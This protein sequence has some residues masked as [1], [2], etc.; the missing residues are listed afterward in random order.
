M[1]NIA[2]LPGGFKPPHAGHYAVAKYLSQKSKA[3]V[4]VRVGSKERGSITQAMS[5]KIWDIYGI[6]AEPAASDSPIADVFKY[7][8]EKATEEDTIYVGTGE[9]DYPRFKVLTDPSFKPD[10]YKKYNPKDVKVIEIPIPPQAGGVSGTKM[11]E[12][13]MNDQKDLFQKYLPDHIDKDKIWNIVLD[14]IQEDLYNPN[15]HVLDYMKSSEFKAGYSKEDD[16]PPGY[17]YRRGGMYSGGGM[18]YGGM[19]EA[20]EKDVEVHSYSSTFAPQINITVVFKEYEKYDELKSLFKGYGYGFYAPESKTIIINGEEFINSDLTLSDLKFVEAHEISHLILNHSGPRSDKDELEADLGAY[21]LLKS[22]DLSVDRLIKQFKFRHGIEFN[23]NLLDDVKAKFSSLMEGDTYEKMAA[24]G[25]KAGNLKQGTVRK[26]LKI[27]DGE[28]IPLSRINKAISR[29]KKMKNR[30]EKNQKYYKALTL[31]KTLKTTTNVKEAVVGD[32]IVCDNCGWTWK[33][34]DGGHDLYICHKCNHDNTPINENFP[35]YKANQVQQTRYKASDVFTRDVQKSKKLGYLEKKDPKKGT[36]K[37]P[38]GSGRR[39]YTDEN[40]SDTVSIKFSTRQDIVDTLNKSS[41]KSKPHKRQSQIINLIH[42]RVRA[43]LNRAKDPEVK[44]RLRSAF[45]Y[46]KKRKEAS[47]NKTQRLKK[48]NVAPNHDGK[49]SPFGSG[50]KP[51]NEKINTTHEVIAKGLEFI[52]K[53][54]T[55]NKG[56]TI[57]FINKEGIHNVNG[58]KSHPRNKNNPGSFKNQVGKGWTFTVKF[59]KS[60]IYNYHCDPHL[61][62]DMVGTIKVKEASKE[63]TQRM[64]NE[65]AFTKNWW[66]EQLTEVLTET[67]ANTH[68]THLEELVLTQGQDGF[69]QAKNFLYE[70]IKNLKGQDNTIKNVSVKW[71]GAP[72]IFTGINPDNGQFFVGTKSVFNKEPKINYTSQDIDK[73][74]G[75]AAGL[76]KKLKLALEYL[77]SV[78]IKGI[79]QGDFMFDSDDVKTD[80]IDG[81]T[82]YTFKPNTIR[83]AVEANSKIGKRILNAKIGIIFHTTYS[84]LSGGGASFGADTSGL[85]ESSNVWFDNAYFKDDTGILLNDKEEAFVLEKIKEADSLNVNYGDLPDEIS[86]RAKINLLNTYLNQEIRKGEFITDPN[87]S[88]ETF[89]NWYKEKIEKVVS[90]ISPKNQDQKRKQLTDKLK[91]FIGAKDTV[92]NLFKVSKLLSEAKNI[93]IAKYDKAVATKHFIDNED[94]TLSVTKAEG[95]VAVDHT[96]SGIKLVDRLEFSKNNFNAGKPGAKK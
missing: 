29:L 45:E 76:A 54:I 69:N 35:P 31:A 63:K 59:S 21:L 52:P 73:N 79:L 88:F 47:K 55:I 37:K 3:E 40:P 77:P 82:H 53:S 43:A 36:G 30:S 62:S 48:E 46:I 50:Y 90:K 74:H 64:K 84:D 42:Q 66:K 6:E 41:F 15:D 12:F 26:R 89:V 5:I 1:A 86:S 25:K 85:N 44:K 56:D 80:D 11:R 38:K 13:I 20:D 94:G 96:E 2:L 71:D 28:K 10:N 17:K 24:K 22:K 32:S 61:G 39:L 34:V 87:K 8:E 51:V 92:I 95:F 7:V 70:L 57:K 27:K 93:F 23:E 65:N 4:L 16:I 72:A 58:D 9:K 60:G 49:S 75:H 19:Y 68:L 83:Y 91:T 14:N 18:G 33:I 81:A 78:G 67:K